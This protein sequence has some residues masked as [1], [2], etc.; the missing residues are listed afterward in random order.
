VC[1]YLKEDSVTVLRYGGCLRI[2]YCG[3][4]FCLGWRKHLETVSY[5]FVLLAVY[6]WCNKIREFVMAGYVACVKASKSLF[7]F[8]ERKSW[9]R[10]R[11]I[12]RGK[13]KAIPVQ[14]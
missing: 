10:S 9:E 11:I 6:Y 2:E 5:T 3:K 4:Y 12:H 1:Q 13:G 7:K 14:A 8:D